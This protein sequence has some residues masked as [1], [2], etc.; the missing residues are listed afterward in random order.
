MAKIC[1]CFAMLVAEGRLHEALRGWTLR[2][3]VLAAG[4]PSITYLV[5]NVCVQ[6][7]YQNLD[8]VAVNILNQS[9]MVFTALFSFLIVGRRQSPMQ[10]VALLLVMISGVLIILSGKPPTSSTNQSQGQSAWVFGTA[11]IVAGSALS[12]LG[13]GMLEWIM[14]NQKRDSYLLTVEM[15]VLGCVMLLCSLILDAT[16]D[17]RVWRQEGLFTR[18]DLLTFIPILSQGWGGIVVGLITKVA[19]GVRKG[20][21]VVVGLIFTCIL[22]WV[23]SGKTPSPYVYVAVPL[24]ALSIYLHANYPPTKTTQVKSRSS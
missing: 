1:G 23:V 17:A 2:G 9:K 5:Q 6:V 12:G 3:A 8:S 14:Q 21:A 4:L 19:G 13:S 16:D 15:A 7:A 20:F 11:C 10:C 22:R 24:V 18:W